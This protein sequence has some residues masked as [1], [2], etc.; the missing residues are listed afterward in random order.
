MVERTITA[1][2]RGGGG[3]SSSVIPTKA[4]RK[5]WLIGGGLAA[6]VVWWAYKKN[7]SNAAA[8][9]ATDTTGTDTT[10]IDPNT[11]LPIDSGS[12]PAFGNTTG[13]T[14]SFAT[15][16]VLGP[17]TNADWTQRA[18]ILLEGYGFDPQAVTRALGAY[19]ANSPLT[20]DQLQIVQAAIG[21]EGNPPIGVPAPHIAPPAGQTTSNIPD[22]YY[23]YV[24]NRGYYKVVNNQRINVRYHPT[25]IA[26]YKKGTRFTATRLNI[27][28][29]PYIGTI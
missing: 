7:V 22:G 21:S 2:E 8:V 26:L 20:N 10:A 17:T 3:G 16:S 25:A 24:P 15:Q 11:G 14:S 13:L 4:N 27:P 5:V 23:Y 19:L 29:L 12:S 6:V 28:K 1:P 18:E 9:A